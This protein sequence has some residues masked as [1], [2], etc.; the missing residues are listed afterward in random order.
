MGED[1]AHRLFQPGKGQRTEE[2]QAAHEQET[3]AEPVAQEG[4]DIGQHGPATGWAPAIPG[5]AEHGE[6]LRLA[7]QVRQ[8]EDAENEQRHDGE[9]RVVGH[10]AGQQQALVGHEGRAPAR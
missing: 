4:I 8:R 6:Q 5:S 10:R 3:D 1:D 9:Q 7:D 2:Q